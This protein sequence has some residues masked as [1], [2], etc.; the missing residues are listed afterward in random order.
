MMEDCTAEVPTEEKKII[1]NES[2]ACTSNDS[3]DEE[4]NSATETTEV[5]SLLLSQRACMPV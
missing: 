2:E 5:F 1:T 4:A 3:P